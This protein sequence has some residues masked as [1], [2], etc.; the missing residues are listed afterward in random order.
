MSTG[1]K[2][3]I[4]PQDTKNPPIINLPY[5]R[6]YTIIIVDV[7]A[8]YPNTTSEPEKNVN[9]PYLHWIKVNTFGN[10]SKSGDE[11]VKYLQCL[12]Q[13]ILERIV[14]EYLFLNRPRK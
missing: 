7:D 4:N 11:V 1:S 12:H 6:L 9:S 3:I 14:I 2:G 8:P 13:G 10:S 5:N